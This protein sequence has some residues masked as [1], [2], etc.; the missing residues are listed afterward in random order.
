MIV[1]FAPEVWA[2]NSASDP[3]GLIEVLAA[4]AHGRHL[5]LLPRAR[6]DRPSVDTWI[7]HQIEAT[8][9]LRKR[10]GRIVEEARRRAPQAP[11]GAAKIT[12][13]ESALDPLRGH[14][15]ARDAARLLQRP[16]KLLVE[17]ARN[18]RA[19][20]RA[21][22]EP[23]ARKEL[24]KALERGWAEFEMG[25]GI[26][27]IKR[28]LEQLRDS[29]ELPELIAR[30]RLWV[31]FDRDADPKD[32]RSES[33]ASREVRELAAELQT[34][35]PLHAHQLRRRAIENYVPV[36]AI[37]RWWTY[38]D[39]K[40]GALEARQA[41][42]EAFG[43]LD[44]EIRRSFNMKKG[45]CG[46]LP[47]SCKSVQDL[48]D[49]RNLDPLYRPIKRGAR[50]PLQTGFERLADA[51]STPGAIVESELH[52]EVEADERRQIMATIRER[53]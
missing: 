2:E 46:D 36:S 25:G 50:L 5:P 41:R 11:G 29:D 27:E 30:A 3:L 52:H 49:D 17:N 38:Y 47:S 12:V 31:M 16:L 23:G 39:L 28:R 45:L 32:R 53:M 24:D 48:Q 44:P 21:V 37:R 51:F 8:S 14:L 6:S 10:L 34:P 20:L 1:A 4:C 35:W 26:G 40:K 15:G 33:P 22:V 7:A 19:F 43:A 18:D 13:V 42:A 9:A